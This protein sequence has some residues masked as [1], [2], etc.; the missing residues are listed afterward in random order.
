MGDVHNNKD[1][2]RSIILEV[3]RLLKTFVVQWS[4]WFLSGC[5]IWLVHIFYLPMASEIKSLKLK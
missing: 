5:Q 2:G 3:K 1:F 4:D